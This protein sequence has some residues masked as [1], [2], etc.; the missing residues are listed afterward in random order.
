MRLLIIGGSFNPVHVGHLIL[1]EEV[2]R[3]FSY[4]RVAFV[5]ARQPPH[6]TIDD[7]PGPALRLAMLRA[8][9]EGDPLYLVDDCELVRE[10]PSYTADTLADILAR[11]EL[12]GKPGL[13]IGDDLASGFASWRDPA[14]VASLADIIVARRSGQR[15]DM[16]FAHRD[17]HNMIV[18]ISST[19]L[20]ERIR[21]GKAW[22]SLV[23]HP[24]A[25][26]IRDAR[27]Y[28]YQP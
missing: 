26:L 1:A 4:D 21:E 2:A 27:L 11:Y 9:V 5:P 10:G 15:Y 14:R 18:P 8:A 17:A 28:G 12:E 7:D 6:K 3:E 23:P 20:R 16:A 13:V 22:R 19:L 24:V 25:K